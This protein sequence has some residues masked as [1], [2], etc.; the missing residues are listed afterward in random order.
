M[1]IGLLGGAFNPPHIG[2]L[3]MAAQGLD[4]AGLDEVWFVPNYGQDPPKPHVATVSHRLAMANMLTLPKTLVSTIEID[5]RLSGNTIELLPHLPKG[6]A[7][8]FILGADWL[9]EFTTWG[10]WQE[11]VTKLPFLV[12]P[13]PGFA[14][15]PLQKN[16]TLLTHPL[17]M[18]NDIS[19]TKIRERVKKGL[20]INP[21]VPP[22][23][24]EYITRHGLYK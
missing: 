9:P 14:N 4:F 19:G 16:M 13:R 18:V 8:T 15:A 6:N 12:F 23:V 24:G 7:Y 10:R 2:H 22:G 1:K 21:F 3:L 20:P 5:H 17:L 11:L